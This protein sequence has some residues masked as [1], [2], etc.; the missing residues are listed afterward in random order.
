LQAHA[1]VDDSGQQRRELVRVHD[2]VLGPHQHSQRPAGADGAAQ[3]RGVVA[4]G[5]KIG[6]EAVGI[7]RRDDILRARRHGE[8]HHG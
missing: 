6:L 4:V 7:S 8:A 5:L 3:V 1:D 2:V